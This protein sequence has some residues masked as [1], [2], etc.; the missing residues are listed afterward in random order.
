MKKL[1]LAG[2]MVALSTAAF[3]GDDDCHYLNEYHAWQGVSSTQVGSCEYKSTLIH[4]FPTYGY[5]YVDLKGASNS[6]CP[7]EL[8]SKV[9]INEKNC[10]PEGDMD[11]FTGSK[12]E[13]GSMYKND[14]SMSIKNV[15][16]HISTAKYTFDIIS[17][18]LQG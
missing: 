12:Q 5:L 6:Q 13:A 3:A 9:Y 11:Y 17:A 2:L 14:D 8:Q 15:Q 10:H 18:K 16:A 7:Q 1:M 4:N